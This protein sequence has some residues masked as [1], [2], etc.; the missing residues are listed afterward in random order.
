[1]TGVSLGVMLSM[2]AEVFDWW[3]TVGDNGSLISH[4]G[5]GVPLSLKDFHPQFS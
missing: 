2:S 1:M 3:R 4:G 5:S